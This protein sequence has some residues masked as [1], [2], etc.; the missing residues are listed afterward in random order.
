MALLPIVS[1][2]FALAVSAIS[3]F[4]RSGI[5]TRDLL[6]LRVDIY[7]WPDVMIPII[8]V[9][10]PPFGLTSIM[11]LTFFPI[12]YIMLMAMMRALDPSL[13]E[14]AATGLE[15]VETLVR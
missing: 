6:G 15:D 13:G 9:Q 12:A 10:L 3:L 1:P 5:I 11:A 7:S 14:A 2:P 8:D 4:G